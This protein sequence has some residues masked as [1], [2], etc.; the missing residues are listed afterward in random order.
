MSRSGSVRTAEALAS[1]RGWVRWVAIAFAAL[2]V[3]V[4]I[5]WAAT[6]VL[7]PPDDVLDSTPFTYVEV[8]NGEVGSSINLN[9]VAEWTPVPVGSNLASGTVT[10]VNVEAGQ[11]I[12]VGTTVYTVNL[13]P[14]VVA[15]GAIPGFRPIGVGSQGADVA[16]LQAMLTTLGLYSGAIDGAFG[17]RT[18]V[19]VKAWQKSL[20]LPQDGMVQPGDVI[21]VP[22]LPTRIALDTEVVKRGAPLMGGE[23]VV[24]GLPP[25]PNFSVPVTDPQASLM[26]T[27]T[28]V[29]ITSPSGATWE[30][31]VVDQVAQE[32]EGVSV[33]LGS[34]DD[35]PIC[36][37]ACT[38]IPVTEQSLLSSRIVTVETVTGLTVPSAAL[39]SGADGS[40]TVIDDVGVEHEVRVLTSARGM[41]I[42]E[43]VPLG[44]MVRVPATEG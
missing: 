32:Q 3:G 15:Q 21:F 30:G 25:A 37:D 22:T 5:G 19:A 29:E 7:T 14:V 13:R 42:I 17:N 2:L 36:E 12:G 40:L 34:R 9:T 41:S 27:G 24:K 28:R 4:A 16:Q 8:V 18:A 39:L 20:G 26:P 6:V 35:A 43:G 10:T 33:I 23:V 44:T 1:R 11:E 38:E 31:F